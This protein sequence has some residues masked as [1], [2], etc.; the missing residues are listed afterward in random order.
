M[1]KEAIEQ[2]Y[3]RRLSEDN[4]HKD[5]GWSFM[6]TPEAAIDSA[7]AVLVGLNPGGH[8]IGEGGEW[9]YQKGVN[10]YVDEAWDPYKAGEHPLQIQVRALF[11]AAGLEPSDVFAGNLV[12][13]RSPAWRDL[14]SSQAAL[15][16][17]AATL[18]MPLLAR[19]PARLFLSLG[20]DAGHQI[21]RLINA[22]K[23][24][25]Q[26]VGW[27]NQKIEE[28]RDSKGRIVLAIPHLSRYKL[29]SHSGSAIVELVSDA[30]KRAFY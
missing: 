16:W 13:F 3:R 11:A 30:A 21:A 19:S 6:Y 8:Q 20:K 28:F 2:E 25:S 18:W 24:S 17:S 9:D 5:W 4:R 27:G 23:S 14:P 7:R 1:T 29:F 10:A 15:D 12:P 22:Q 26:P